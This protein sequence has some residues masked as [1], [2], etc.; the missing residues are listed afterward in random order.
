MSEDIA[1]VF[2][3]LCRR[4]RGAGCRDHAAQGCGSQVLIVE[5]R[6]ARRASR[7]A[8]AQR[9]VDSYAPPVSR[10]PPRSSPL[11]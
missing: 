7:Y 5:V 4:G 11:R 8:Y 1:G 6:P 10:R 9:V 2:E 3:K